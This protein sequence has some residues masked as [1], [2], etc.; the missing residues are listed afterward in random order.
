MVR[1]VLAAC[2]LGWLVGMQTGAVVMGSILHKPLGVPIAFTI[3]MYPAVGV[4]IASLLLATRRS[5]PKA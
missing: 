1:I 3:F 4:V 5:A 2:A